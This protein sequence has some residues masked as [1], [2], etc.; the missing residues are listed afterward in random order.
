MEAISKDL[1]G[2]L[3]AYDKACE[4]FG[5]EGDKEE[6][7]EAKKVLERGWLTLQEALLMEN[8][9]T[10]AKDAFK[11]NEAVKAIFKE[12]AKLEIPQTKVFPPLLKKAKD[13]AKGV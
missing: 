1:S 3:L 5:K 11:C 8:I 9:K 10:H 12:L 2:A 4:K 7:G 6:M 13:A